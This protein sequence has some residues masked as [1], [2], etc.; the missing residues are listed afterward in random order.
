[1]IGEEKDEH[2]TL[3]AALSKSIGS[4]SLELLVSSAD[5]ISDKLVDSGALDSIPIFG[6]L[7][8][9]YKATKEIRK[10]LFT[11]SLEQFL[12]QL[13]ATTKEEREAFVRKLENDGELERF[14]ETFLLILDRVDSASK[15]KIYG[16]ILAAHISGKIPSF[17]KVKRLVAIVNRIYVEDLDYLRSFSSG[18][19][20]DADVAVSLFSAG[21]LSNTGFD[22]GGIDQSQEPGGLTY[23]LNEYGELLLAHGFE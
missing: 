17:T 4:D 6:L 2:P 14:G 16:R 12:R 20:K 7:S 21:F 19:Q 3:G 9:G 18:V 1:M 11:R 10:Y 8:G 22:G 15:P 13:N 5:V 23:A